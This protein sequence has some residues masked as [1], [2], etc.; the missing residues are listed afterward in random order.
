MSVGVKVTDITEDRKSTRLNSS[1]RC[2]SYA[3]FCLKKKKKDTTTSQPT[4]SRGSRRG[5]FHVPPQHLPNVHNP[6]IQHHRSTLPSVLPF[7]FFFLKEPAPPET[8]P[9][10]PPAPLRF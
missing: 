6:L 2:I 7:F 1:H 10:S 5:D 9:F 8:S 4:T 3:V